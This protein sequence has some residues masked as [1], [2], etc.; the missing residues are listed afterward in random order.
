MSQHFLQAKISADMPV[1]LNAE[2]ALPP[3]DPAL[4]FLR[5]SSHFVSGATLGG[6]VRTLSGTSQ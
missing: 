5:M 3:D 4:A 1:M 2:S 6:A